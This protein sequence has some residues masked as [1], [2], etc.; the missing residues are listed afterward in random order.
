[1]LV[2]LTRR[3]PVSAVCLG[4]SL[5]NDV[6]FFSPE[7]HCS[8]GLNALLR[9]SSLRELRTIIWLRSRNVQEGTDAGAISEFLQ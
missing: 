7:S 6:G 2:F 1:M 9:M 3:Q 8:V 5:K 4:S